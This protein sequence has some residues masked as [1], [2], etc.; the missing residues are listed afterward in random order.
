MRIKNSQDWDK[1]KKILIC[2]SEEAVRESLK[3]ILGD[4][5]D[6]ILIENFEMLL[7]TLKHASIEHAFIEPTADKKQLEQIKLLR[8]ENLTLKITL[9]GHRK[10]ED[11]LKKMVEGNNADNYLSM[12]FRSG[13]ILSICKN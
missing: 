4:L 9:V 6:L 7:D 5:Y 1:M 11:A 2:S 8:Q 12:P 3:L 13:E 10:S